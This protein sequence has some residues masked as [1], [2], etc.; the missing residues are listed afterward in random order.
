MMIRVYNREGFTDSPLLRIM[1]SGPPAT[2]TTQIIIIERN[3]TSLLVQMPKVVDDA[4]VLSY[5]LQ[6][7]DGEGG[8]FI[9]LGGFNISTMQTE[10]Q[11][12]NLTAGLVYRLRYRVL[13]FV[14]W[15]TFSPTLYALVATV[16]SAPASPSLL[17]ATATSITLELAESLK[18]GG[19]K[20]TSY[21]LWM[22]SGYGTAFTKV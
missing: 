21:E 22:D 4:S 9:S 8:S 11:I 14:G 2:I 15:S 20:V 18:N 17:S 7:D 1:N 5:E 10:Y 13:N 16:P 3:E 6:I 19:S 12:S